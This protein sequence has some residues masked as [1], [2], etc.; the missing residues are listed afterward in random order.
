M[1]L[2]DG[3][4]RD[5]ETLPAQRTAEPR[6]T[7]ILGIVL[8]LGVI[9]S[10]TGCAGVYVVEKPRWPAPLGST[11]VESTSWSPTR[12]PGLLG[13][14][15]SSGSL[16]A[17][18]YCEQ[19]RLAE[20]RGY[21][22]KDCL[23][24][25][26]LADSLAESAERPIARPSE[27][28]RWSIEAGAFSWFAVARRSG[29]DPG[30]ILEASAI[31][32]RA[33]ERCVRFSGANARQLDPSWT[34]RLARL[35]I[36]P[37]IVNPRWAHLRFGGLRIS[38]DSWVWGLSPKQE[39]PGWGVP[40]V[41]VTDCHG[42][43]GAGRFYPEQLRMA[44]TLA[45]RPQGSVEAGTWRLRPILLEIHDPQARDVV[46]I[47]P[48]P[49]FPLAFDFSTPLAQQ[50]LQAHLIVK[51]NI[52]LFDPDRIRERA[53]LFMIRPYEPGK[54]PVIMV[55]GL[56]SSPRAWTK[57]I[58]AFEGDP[59][60]RARYQFWVAFYP[61]GDPIPY[62]SYVIRQALREARRTLDPERRD[63]AFDQIVLLGHSMG[64]LVS[65]LLVQSGEPQLWDAVFTKPHE[66]IQLATDHR[67]LVCAILQP[68]QESSI[69]RVVFLATPHRG[70][71]LADQFLGRFSSSLVRRSNQLQ[72]AHDHAL[73]IN[74]PEIFHP[75]FRDRAP[76]SI[77]N[78]KWDG[79]ILQRMYARAIAPSVPYHSIIGVINP[80]WQVGRARATDGVVAYFSAHLPG[81]VSEK[82][83]HRNHF[84]NGS[85]EAI[86]EVRRILE[87]HL[88]QVEPIEGI[89]VIPDARESIVPTPEFLEIHQ[90]EDRVADDRH[91]LLR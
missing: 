29:D 60:F 89:P 45:L 19:E 57:M 48:D 85:P 40:V 15:R 69:T 88:T 32:A 68:S 3:S 1:N 38:A 34:N 28:L 39:Q 55:H 30:L 23:A 75:E 16:S 47:G 58:N 9:S 71:V 80:G 10:L 63:P 53:G 17:E 83:I 78:L 65:K 67:E 79:P 22:A 12:S 24:L 35:G 14:T 42:M 49:A 21:P 11:V 70:S 27:A 73:N 37:T 51:E 50:V 90:S 18:R 2:L 86:A 13:S 41:T 5:F 59:L 91:D 33:V 72:T 87:L 7:L 66:E 46:R 61:T 25:A 84:L 62:S 4:V 54:I 76:S 64:G 81:A 8:S 36:T 43:H 26:D 20:S 52:G 77:D 6:P 44:A 56:Y 82:V 31:Q 74:G